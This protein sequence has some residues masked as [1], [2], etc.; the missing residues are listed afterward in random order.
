ML[1]LKQSTA[2][3]S[4]LLGP[5]VDDTDGT[6]A[7]DGLT[8][9]NTDI[10][11][12]KAGGGMSAKNSGGGSIDTNGWYTITLNATDTNT[13]GRLQIS[14][15]VAGALAVFMEMH[16]LEEAIYDSLIAPSAAAFDFKSKSRCW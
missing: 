12:S 6:T 2:S 5:F 14:C 10:L 11:L 8:I 3:Q 7:E 16:V 1:Y 15:K 4:I 9:A 13:V